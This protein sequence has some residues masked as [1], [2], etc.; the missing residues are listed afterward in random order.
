MYKL[1]PEVIEK[2]REELIDE[3]DSLRELVVC[4]KFD[5]S[6]ISAIADRIDNFSCETTSGLAVLGVA[7]SL[8]RI[9]DMVEE[10]S[11]ENNSNNG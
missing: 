5:K 4:S 3:I 7:L 6:G 9:K 10:V 1:K 8:D 2:I 11:D